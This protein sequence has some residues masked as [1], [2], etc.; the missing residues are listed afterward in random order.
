M[1]EETHASVC[2]QSVSQRSTNALAP[3]LSDNVCTDAR[4]CGAS[5]NVCDRMRDTKSSLAYEANLVDET[6]LSSNCLIFSL[7]KQE[8]RPKAVEEVGL[9]PF[10]F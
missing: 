7:N 10:F 2:R 9:Y 1:R 6:G 5:K 3:I 4:V 8:N